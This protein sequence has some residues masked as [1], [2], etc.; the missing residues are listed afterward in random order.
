MD[1]YSHADRTVLPD[2]LN[3]LF[4]HCDCH[5]QPWCRAEVEPEDPTMCKM[6]PSSQRYRM[7]DG[8]TY[9]PFQPGAAIEVGADGKISYARSPSGSDDYGKGF[10]EK[11]GPGRPFAGSPHWPQLPKPREHRDPSGA[12]PEAPLPAAFRI[13]RVGHGESPGIQFRVPVRS[14]GGVVTGS[15][16]VPC[17]A[18]STCRIP[19]PRDAFTERASEYLGDLEE[20]MMHDLALYEDKLCARH[21][22]RLGGDRTFV[23]T[24]DSTLRDLEAFVG[25]LNRGRPEGLRLD[26]VIVTYGM[27]LVLFGNDPRLSYSKGG[28]P[29]YRN[30][31]LQGGITFL[32]P[33][34]APSEFGFAVSRGQGPVFVHGPTTVSCDDGEAVVE[35]HCAVAAPPESGVPEVPWGVRFGAREDRDAGGAGAPGAPRGSGDRHG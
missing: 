13:A 5:V 20:D 25:E 24:S 33:E 3:L 34:S 26:T 30:M 23:Y 32:H 21:F 9:C 31:T 8:L 27:Y 14:G 28:Y 16:T 22:M 6:C 35:R 4:P 12:A 15:R 1:H 19:M 10:Y 2:A 11:R 18:L 17:P 7:S 29:D